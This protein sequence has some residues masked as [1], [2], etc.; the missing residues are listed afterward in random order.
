MLR[1]LSIHDPAFLAR[2]SE[3]NLAPTLDW[4]ARVVANGGAAP[5]Q[6]TLD[7]L[8]T[9]Y[10]AL[11]AAGL[12]SKMKVVNVYAPDSLTACLTPYFV[13]TGSDPWG[14]MGPFTSS[15]LTVNGLKGNGTTM[16]LDTGVLLET[17]FPAPSNSHG[18]TLYTF[19]GLNE[20]K[21]DGG[22][23]D[24][25][26][27]EQLHHLALATTNLNYSTPSA[28]NVVSVANNNFAGYV[29]MQRINSTDLEVYRA[30]SG[31]AHA[32]LGSYTG[33]KVG[34]LPAVRSFY[35]HGSNNVGTLAFAC[36]RRLSFAAL[37]DGLTSGESS[38]LF[39]AVQQL[40][41]DFGGGYA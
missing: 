6:A 26:G 36:T 7:A 5:A 27:V 41:T 8:D 28:G 2:A 10:S 37:H 40:R 14:N 11:V 17:E 22:A 19:D 25:G 18:F 4:A 39:D 20:N 23:T 15:E 24:S 29:C 30:N 3:S 9:F 33:V 38:D 32:L 13:G 1:P 34:S 31:T 21:R 16:A 35:V 12:D